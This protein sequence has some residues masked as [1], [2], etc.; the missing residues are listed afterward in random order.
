MMLELFFA[1]IMEINN[2]GYLDKK[3]PV[4]ELRLT[5]HK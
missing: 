2:D 4:N 1:I 3:K 5:A